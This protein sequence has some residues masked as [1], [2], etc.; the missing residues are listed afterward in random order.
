L[1]EQ[2]RKRVRSRAGQVVAIPL[3]DG[4]FGLGHV[5]LKPY[6]EITVALFARRARSPEELAAAMH[7]ALAEDPIATLAVPDN[8]ICDGSWAVI[9]S[10]ER[11]YPAEVL[12]K[13]GRSFSSS[14]APNL[15]SAYHGLLP[16]DERGPRAPAAYGD[17]L[18]PGVKV[19]PT[20]RYTKDLPP[21]ATTAPAPATEVTEGPAE[22][23]IQIVYPGDVLPSVELLRRRQELER[24]LEE[25]GAGEVT[26]AGSG[27]G[28]MDVYLTTDDV[29]R[30]LPLVRKEIGALGFES[31]TLIETSLPDQDDDG[32]AD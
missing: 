32:D 24:R 19:P 6:L 17:N 2:K 15:L 13:H 7:E 11:S 29:Q 10:S 23:H 12:D 25:A 28:V 31:D 16:W 20:V 3:V 1:A 4:T 18:L 22:V 8:P 30:A 21:P 26:D 5:A 27:G 14:Y 9:G